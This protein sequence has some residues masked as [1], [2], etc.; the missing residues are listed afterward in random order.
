[1]YRRDLIIYLIILIPALRFITEYIIENAPVCDAASRIA[2][3]ITVKLTVY[4]L[5]KS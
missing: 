1:M 4:L 2:E 3:A 5:Q